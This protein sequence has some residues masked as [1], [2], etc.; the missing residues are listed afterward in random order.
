MNSLQ[1]QTVCITG[2]SSGIGKATA[3]YFAHQGWNV[4]AT[5]RT[6]EKCSDLCS[7]QNITCLPLDVTNEQAIQDAM[8]IVI[9]KYG[10]IDVLVNNAGFGAV[11]VFEAATEEDVQKQ[12][13]VNVFGLMRVMRAV[14]PPMRTQ[15]G[16]TIIN[17]ASMGGRVCF[18]LYSIYHST[19][20][21]V[22]GL[23]ES[24]AF[25]LRPLNIKMKIIEPGAIQTDFYS[26]SMSVLQKDGLNAY[27]VTRQKALPYM[28]QA[29]NDAAPP[30]RVAAVIY[31]AA[32][33]GKWKLRYSAAGGSR[34][35]LIARKLLPDWA[36]NN[37]IR[38]YIMR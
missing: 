9:E 15:G 18:P 33:D 2:A 26:R 25:E 7:T 27:D 4:V 10:R 1:K 28:T 22:E 6:P 35:I 37:L 13:A 32:T 11:G 12:Y 34:A 20:W 16:G 30:E 38:W 8:N 21:A 31:R 3:L 17:I 19:K 24:M 29:G 23:S 14:L 36:F 5:M